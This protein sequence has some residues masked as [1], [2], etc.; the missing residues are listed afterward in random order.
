MLLNSCITYIP[1]IMY[2]GGR[3]FDQTGEGHVVAQL[4][5]RRLEFDHFYFKYLYK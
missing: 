5:R 2:R 1:A 4:Y 3:C